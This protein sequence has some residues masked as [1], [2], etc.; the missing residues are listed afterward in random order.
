MSKFRAESGWSDPAPPNGVDGRE[1]LGAA[2]SGAE[3]FRFKSSREPGSSDLAAAEAVISEGRLV[4]SSVAGTVA[5]ETINDEP[6]G[7]K[8][9]AGMVV[10]A[11]MVLGGTVL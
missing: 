8:S 7:A 3:R 6:V 11:L 1:L 2:A 10:G 4:S 5:G 9:V